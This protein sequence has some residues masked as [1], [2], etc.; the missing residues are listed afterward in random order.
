MIDNRSNNNELHTCNR[1]YALKLASRIDSGD[2]AI[3]QVT[4]SLFEIE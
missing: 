4:Y 1:I 2:P 3:Q